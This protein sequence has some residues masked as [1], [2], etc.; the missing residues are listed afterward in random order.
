MDLHDHPFR[1]L[2]D[3]TDSAIPRVEGDTR[4]VA[5]V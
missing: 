3:A 5:R 2:V 4:S 1:V